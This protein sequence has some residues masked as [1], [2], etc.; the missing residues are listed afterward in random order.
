MFFLF[1]LSGCAAD[2]VDIINNEGNIV[3]ECTAEFNWHW[4]GVND[5]VDYILNLC[6]QTYIAQGYKLSNGS[7]L[8]NNYTLPEPPRGNL[9]NKKIAYEQ[10]KKGSISE[11]KYGYI[12]AA[13]EYE[14]ILKTNAANKKLANGLINKADY[15]QILNKAK[16]EFTGE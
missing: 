5:S 10:F 6:A 3:G 7:I 12:L 11:Q 13:I 2:R 8:E 14:Y 4:Y 1:F 16:T 9:W 15:K